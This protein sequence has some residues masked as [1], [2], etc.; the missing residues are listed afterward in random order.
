MDQ[1]RTVET[2]KEEVRT[3]LAAQ[4]FA[5][6]L[7]ATRLRDKWM[8]EWAKSAPGDIERREQLYSKVALLDEIL[9]EA[10]VIADS[11]QIAGH[12]LKQQETKR[13]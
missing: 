8:D 12:K 5:E 1:V 9:H 3:G 11:G 10:R 2:L 7:I 13:G 4:G 6:A